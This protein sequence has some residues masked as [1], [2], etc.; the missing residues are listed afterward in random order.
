[1]V[2]DV[3]HQGK[4]GVSRAN[5]REQLAKMYKVDDAKRI[6]LGGMKLHFG[7]GRTTCFAC[8]YDNLAVAQ[9]YAP[10]YQLLRN[11]IVE[12][13]ESGSRKQRKE[14]KNRDKKFRGVKKPAKAKK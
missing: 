11:G 9:K 4:S 2:V 14:R 10:K 6:I 12:P 5:L 7:G 13:K 3:F 1:M 8:V